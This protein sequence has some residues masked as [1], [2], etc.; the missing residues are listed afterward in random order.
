[1]KRRGKNNGCKA[2]LEGTQGFTEGSTYFL[3]CR[4]AIFFFINSESPALYLFWFGKISVFCFFSFFFVNFT[5]L[6]C[7]LKP[8]LLELFLQWMISFIWDCSNLEV[9][10]SWV[11]IGYIGPVAEDMF[12][13]QATIMG[14]A[15]SPYAGGVFLV[16]IHFPPDYPFKPPKVICFAVNGAIS[17]FDL[18][19]WLDK[20]AALFFFARRDNDVFFYTLFRLHLG[21][22][23][24]IP[25]LIVMEAFVLISSKS[26]G[27]LLLPFLRFDFALLIY[28]DNILMCCSSLLLL[29]MACSSKVCRLSSVLG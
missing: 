1:M 3:Q 22:R 6:G 12:H 21:P 14:P 19:M 9:G 7:G 26:S 29:A 18:C 4:C 24:F 11:L 10:K 28:A 2:Y 5:V 17:D 27:V 8:T 13:W 16:T 15:D 25:T 20:K 23:S